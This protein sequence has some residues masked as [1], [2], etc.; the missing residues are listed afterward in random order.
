[1]NEFDWDSELKIHR[2]RKLHAAEQWR[3]ARAAR[4]ARGWTING[5][6]LGLAEH[7]AAEARRAANAVQG[8]VSGPSGP[9]EESC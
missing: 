5:K 4:P 8:W 7:A 2:H 3:W 9:Q 1:M 6:L